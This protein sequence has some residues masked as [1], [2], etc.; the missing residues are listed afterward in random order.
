MQQL[1]AHP[2]KFVASNLI[3]RRKTV[4]NSTEL[5]ASG[6]GQPISDPDL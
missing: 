6:P 2:S 1:S 3:I 5:T 4:E